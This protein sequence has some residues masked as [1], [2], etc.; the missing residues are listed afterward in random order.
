DHKEAE[1][2]IARQSENHQ[3]GKKDDAS[4]FKKGRNDPA[5]QSDPDG[6]RAEREAGI[7][8][9]TE[10]KPGDGANP[11]LMTRTAGGEE[12]TEKIAK[13]RSDNANGE[14]EPEEGE[15]TESD[16]EKELSSVSSLSSSSSSS[17]A[18][19]V[20]PENDSPETEMETQI[21]E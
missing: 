11:I 9:R 20:H 16:G 15:I 1:P 10:R 2:E 3:R 19:P 5:A 8:L 7:A 12:K 21:Q 4:S 18:S 6:P 14:S 17:P 13:S